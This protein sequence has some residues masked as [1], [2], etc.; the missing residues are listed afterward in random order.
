MKAR[1]RVRE[2]VQTVRQHGKFQDSPWE[3]LTAL[4]VDLF[5]SPTLP[6]IILGAAITATIQTLY[7]LVPLGFTLG[8]WT[9][10]VLSLVVYAV[11]DEV[12]RAYH[13]ASQELDSDDRGI[14]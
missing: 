6:N 3:R 13:A 12:V 7:G 1:D 2:V 10:W 8:T 4:C 5:V 11:G 14:E 9:A